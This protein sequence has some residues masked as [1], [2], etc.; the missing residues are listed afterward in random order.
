MTYRE[1]QAAR[2]EWLTSGVRDFGNL[3]LYGWF[4]LHVPA[5]TSGHRGMNVHRC[6]LAEDYTRVF[7]LAT[8]PRRL[9][10]AEGVRDA[11]GVLMDYWRTRRWAIPADQYPWYARAAEERLGDWTPWTTNPHA[12]SWSLDERAEV[13][14]L[15]YPLKPFGVPMPAS[16]EQSLD[17]WL[18]ADLSRH[19]VVDAAYAVSFDDPWLSRVRTNEQIVVTHSL[20]K[21][22][23]APLRAGFVHTHHDDLRELF[24][25]RE[26]WPLVEQAYVVLNQIP[27]VKDELAD[28]LRSAYEGAAA[29]SPW[30]LPPLDPVNPSYLFHLPDADWHELYDAGFLTIPASV[31]GI[32]SG[33]VVSTLGAER[34][35]SG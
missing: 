6:H 32:H 28:R 35:M 16:M 22:F 5:R 10:V 30:P 13:V 2:P 25:S 23:A 14:L 33:V 19:L 11:L 4:D 7:G 8:D 29:E 18:S 15:C 3:D 27:H 9:A 31:Y 24:T 17:R 21:P 1:Y 20:S 34:R 26:R 12:S